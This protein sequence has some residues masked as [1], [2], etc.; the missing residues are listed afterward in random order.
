MAK[1]SSKIY[2]IGINP[3]VDPPDEALTAVFKQAG[4]SKGAI[5]VRGRLDGAE[6]IQTLVKYQGAWR[7]YINGEMLKSS[8]LRVGDTATVEMAFDPRS[9]EAPVPPKFARVL[10]ADKSAKAEFD[11]LSPSR[12]KEILRYLGSLKT[13]E[14]LDRNIE[15][16]LK[17]LRGEKTDALHAMMRKPKDEK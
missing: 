17:H 14:S 8:G 1:F 3:V 5:P 11:A 9:R 4:R 16:T 12:Q 15:R 6:F 13:E 2:K 7:L 10:L